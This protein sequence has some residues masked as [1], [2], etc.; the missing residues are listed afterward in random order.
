MLSCFSLS[1]LDL[2][3]RVFHPNNLANINNAFWCFFLTLSFEN[4]KY[5]REIQSLLWLQW[6]QKILTNIHN[7]IINCFC[8][9]HMSNHFESSTPIWCSQS[10]SYSSF[11]S[12]SYW[13]STLS[14]LSSPSRSSNPINYL[15]EEKNIFDSP[16]IKISRIICLST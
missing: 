5:L 2:I 3:T 4:I 11:S 8:N 16:I 15:S 1:L 12:S 6:L 14:S 9:N 13:S 10:W 7:K